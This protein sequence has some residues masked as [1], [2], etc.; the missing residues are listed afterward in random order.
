MKDFDKIKKYIEEKLLDSKLPKEIKKFIESN[1]YAKHEYINFIYENE[2]IV[3]HYHLVDLLYAI[4]Y[5]RYC[6]GE[7]NFTNKDLNKEALKELGTD[8]IIGVTKV[9]AI[10][11]IKGNIYYDCLPQIINL[12]Y[13]DECFKFLFI[14]FYTQILYN[15]DFLKLK[16]LSNL[17]D[18]IRTISNKELFERFQQWCNIHKNDIAGITRIQAIGCIVEYVLKNLNNPD[19]LNFL[20]VNDIRL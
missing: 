12:K 14:L 9:T 17:L 18:N 11:Y 6:K 4:L 20:K 7:D 19:F 13:N 10:P 3:L 2:N 16:E 8:N 15:I 1:D 5:I